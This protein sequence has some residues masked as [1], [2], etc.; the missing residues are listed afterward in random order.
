M[1]RPSASAYP[2]AVP[3]DPPGAGRRADLSPLG[4]DD[5]LPVL[6][7]N[8]LL[9]GKF[10]RP[11]DRI[12]VEKL[13]GRTPPGLARRA[14][15]VQEHRALL[16]NELIST[17]RANGVL[18]LATGMPARGVVQSAHH[19]LEGRQPATPVV[20]VEPNVRLASVVREMLASR[21][22]RAA[23]AVCADPVDATTC[24][25]RATATGL[26]DPGLP[27][28]LDGVGLAD[29]IPDPDRQWHTLAGWARLLP[30]GSVLLLSLPLDPRA[31]DPFDAAADA[32]WRPDPPMI[33]LP[34]WGEPD[35]S[36]CVVF[37]RQDHEPAPAGGDLR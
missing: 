13:T 23:T 34:S 37:D 14:R 10:N 17:G 22:V 1:I 27:V 5:P 19:A 11:V 26:L 21:K 15:A 2:T 7:L 32:G 18:D 36:L 25:A 20:Y 33:P 29:R 12:H 6:V 28:V 35:P 24:W 4:A 8:F 3:A 16:L 30:P 9:D 31:A